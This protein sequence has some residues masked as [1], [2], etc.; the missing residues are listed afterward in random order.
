[1]T[2]AAA[3]ENLVI[4]LLSQATPQQLDLVREMERADRTCPAD[5]IGTR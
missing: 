2:S 1:L 5:Q 4:A 3:L